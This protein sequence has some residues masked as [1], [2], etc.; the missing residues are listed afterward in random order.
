VNQVY[1]NAVQN[2]AADYRRCGRSII[3]LK[4]K[5]A[6]EPW[7]QY[8]ERRMTAEEIEEKPWAGVGIVTGA[9]SGVVVLDADS[10][11]A[12]EELK[13]RGHPVT[14]MAKT[15]RGMHLYF[16]HPGGELPTAIG[17][18]DGLDLKGDGGYVV[19][20][21]SRHPTGAI[22]VWVIS[23]DDA[24]PA[25]LPA[26]VMEQVQARS[27]RAT[28]EDLGEEIP[29]GSRNKVL[30]SFAGT[31]RRR[32]LGETAIFAALLGINTEMCKPPL[33]ENEVQKIAGSVG[34]Y[35]PEDD[36][37]YSHHTQTEF[38]ENKQNHGKPL[39]IKTVEQVIEEAGEEVPWIVKNLLARGALTDFSGLAKDSGKTTFW[40][41]AISAGARGEQHAGFDTTPAKYLYLTEQGNNFALALKD[42]GLT[43]HPDHIRIVQF[44]DV[45]AL[46]WNTL[47]HQAGAEAARRGLDALAV[48][49]FA[50]F[51]RLKGSEE[52]DAGPVAD[53]MRVLRQVAQ[54][55]NIGVALIRHAGK[56]GT[57]RGSSAFEAEADICVTLDK[58]E[59]R[60]APTVRRL[61]AKG[62]YGVW[63][64][65]IQLH[66]GRYISLGTDD[67]VEFNKAVR[68]IKSVLPEEEENAIRKQEIMDRRTGVDAEVSAST[69][70]RALKW[71]V[72]KGVVGEKQLTGKQGKP[73]V[74]WLK[75]DVYFHQTTSPNGGNKPETLSGADANPNDRLW[76]ERQAEQNRCSGKPSCLCDRCFPS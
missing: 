3:R 39:P 64:R 7:A 60:H 27:R 25:E 50:V 62:R 75:P 32:G 8:Q 51:A 70:D 15:A 56:D 29:N 67:K 66:E 14:P 55:Y 12:V 37:F 52:N 63:E 16:Q 6:A 36:S 31:L 47:M 69:L 38:G 72:G 28:P 49:T 2:A 68:F 10:P 54:K 34:R 57:P 45:T 30:T 41:H 4:G 73:K 35:E 1:A 9:I 18:G 76:R 11:E 20:P 22:Y 43:E 46:Q 40:C 53:R 5:I 48:D 44:K 17:L 13:R 19:A 74:F 65:N 42:S 33:P 58:P 61:T 26:W 71:L 24:S 59:G 23:P 21:P